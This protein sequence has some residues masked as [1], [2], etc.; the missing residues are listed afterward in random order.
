MENRNPDGVTNEGVTV[1]PDVD[2]PAVVTV[3]VDD[4]VIGDVVLYSQYTSQQGVLV[5]GDPLLVLSRPPGEGP[6]GIDIG[7]SSF[8]MNVG[9]TI[10]IELY[11]DYSNDVR[12]LQYVA[13]DDTV[14]LTSSNPS[15]VTVDPTRIVMFGQAP[16][17]ATITAS[18]HGFTTQASVTV[19]PLV[20]P[21]PRLLNISTRMQVQNGDNVLIGGFIVTGSDSKKVI[22]RGIGPSLGAAGISNPLQDPHLELHNQAGIVASNEDWKDTQESEIVATGI[23]PNDDKEAAIVTTLSPGAYTVILKQ[24]DG[25]TGV[26]L[27]E[28]YDLGQTANAKLANISTRGFVDTGDDVMIGGFIAGGSLGGTGSILVRA[29]GPSLAASGVSGALEDPTLELHD[30]NGGLLGA[31][32]N[33]KDTQS[34][35]IIATGIPPTDDREAAIVATLTEG[36]YTAIVRGANGTVGVALVEAYQLSE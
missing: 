5:L 28:A 11:A 31:N 17:S 32:D 9:D 35:D 36:A 23:S 21:P 30:S 26:G 7:Q 33:W 29:L 20:P 8:I 12:M 6:L 25:G 18:F 15:V 1:T 27:V 16:G 10:P 4:A 24:N 3:T 2:D 34:A 13:A 22:L 14:E 19:N